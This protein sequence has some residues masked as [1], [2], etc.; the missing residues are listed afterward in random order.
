[1][2]CCNYVPCSHLETYGN[3]L[4]DIALQEDGIKE[5]RKPGPGNSSLGFEWKG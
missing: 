3:V 1:M 4:R 5:R 2:Y